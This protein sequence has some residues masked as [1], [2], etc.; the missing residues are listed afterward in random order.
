MFR[1]LSLIPNDDGLISSGHATR[2]LSSTSNTYNGTCSIDKIN[3]P[4]SM[5]MLSKIEKIYGSSKNVQKRCFLPS[6]YKTLA[7]IHFCSKS[8]RVYS[9]YCQTACNS[10]LT[11]IGT[12]ADPAFMFTGFSN[13]KNN[14]KYLRV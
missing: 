4:I 12:K 13:E 9:Y 2:C 14:N 5:A 10:K 11:V 7:C 3:Q 8:L 1:G 6:L